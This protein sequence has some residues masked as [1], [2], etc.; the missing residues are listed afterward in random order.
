MSKLTILGRGQ[1]ID[2]PFSGE[3]L[4]CDL[5]EQAGFTGMKP[6]GGRGV[7]GKCAVTLSGDISQPNAAEQKAGTRLACQATVFG[8]AEVILPETKQMEQIQTDSG[9]I[10]LGHPMEGTLGAVVDLGTTT[11]AMKVYDLTTGEPVGESACINPQISVAADVMGRIGAAMNGQAEKL[12]AQVTDTIGQML[13]DS[14]ADAEKVDLLAI[15]GNTT[16]LYL[17]TQRDPTCLS[18]A[19]FQADTL[20]DN[21]VTFLSRKTYL[22]PCMNAFVGADITCA[23]LASGM[24]DSPATAL[25]CDIG[26]NGEIA[27]WKDG[28]LY[29][30]S[31]AAGPAFE[32][33]G[34]SCGCGS[35]GGAIDK[36][37]AQDDELR[38]HTIGE[39]PAVGLCGSGLIDAVAALLQLEWMDET[40]ALDDDDVTLAENVVLLQK[41][42]RAVQLA[43]AAIAAGIQTLVELSGSTYEEIEALYIA[44]G[45]GSHLN[46]SSAVAIGL[47]PEAL[48]DKTHIIGNAALAGV[49]QLMLDREK[50]QKARNIAAASRSINLGGNPSFN[51]NYVENML[52][53]FED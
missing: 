52:F 38:I 6:C 16:M 17:L 37:W 18:A 20:F 44:G 23:V 13:H 22:P 46:V 25:L 47:L 35:V 1:R 53:P 9:N 33:A 43:K 40:G 29:V 4:L 39:K 10:L 34:I 32:G 15:T 5:L 21:Y 42:I 31:T 27:L 28:T 2:F 24:C 8:D 12:C 41:D 48:Q 36:V 30:T 14:G 26:T 50:L 11:I 45:F 49:S 3:H 51:E 7:C 19:P